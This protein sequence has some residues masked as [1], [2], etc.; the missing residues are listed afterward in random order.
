MA[1]VP[2]IT[3]SDNLCIEQVPDACGLVVFGATGDLTHRKLLP[4][5]FG[6]QC[7]RL[8]PAQFFLLGCGRTAL[9]DE[10]FRASVRDTLRALPEND[11]GMVASF[12]ARCWYQQGVYD[13]PALY[14][15]LR[16][17]MR[18]LHAANGTHGNT[19]FYLSTPPS[20]YGA[21]VARLGAARL[22]AEHEDGN[23]W[24][25]V[26]VEKPHGRDL[27]TAR[28]LARAL[29][30]AL[31]ET[32][33]YRIDHYLGKETVQNI[34]IFRFA[35][36]VFEP[37]WN[38]Q[39]IDNVQITAAEC[40]G[41][42]HRAGYFEQAGMLRDFFQNHLLQM[43]A[44]VAME[45]PASS[46]APRMH[47]GKAQLLRSLRPFDPATLE[48]QIIRGQ[49]AAGTV[50]NMT[51]P[52]YRDEPGVAGSSI[53]ET[54]VAAR[55]FIDNW[56]WQGVPF[57]LRA[58]K[59]LPRRCSEIAVTFKHVPHSVFQPLQPENLAPNALVFN[60]QPDEGIALS[61]QAKHP[62]PRLCMSTLT[63]NFSY[64]SVFHADPPEAYERLLLDCM[65]GDQTLFIREDSVETTWSLLQP[66][67]DTW[68]VCSAEHQLHS[69]AAGSWGPDAAD[70]LPALDG[71]QWRALCVEHP[72]EEC[73]LTRTTAPGCS[74]ISKG[75]AP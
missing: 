56:R 51:A 30:V 69:Y 18:G 73:R 63:M 31:A 60:V 2:Y 20:V 64:R 67:L 53:V 21:I 22:A 65:L 75:S 48:Q 13:S 15:A 37:L 26:I 50:R 47:D 49:Y 17:R 74:A 7:K 25:R 12:C 35:N 19:V 10:S 42:E 24:M 14:A 29:R 62:G 70:A 43:L 40:M 34:L 45:P 23:G 9:S 52:G 11:E 36:A 58:G 1:A 41:V 6:L 54:Y 44:L 28:E 72:C 71:R 61:I 33:I 3:V 55:L 16:D 4:S 66:V 68:R 46:E 8:L 5:L 59:R 38:R 32:Q 27:A 57:Y 39:Y